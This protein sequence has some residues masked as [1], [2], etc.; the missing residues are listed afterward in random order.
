MPPCGEGC[1]YFRKS[2]RFLIGLE[3]PR[4]AGGKAGNRKPQQDIKQAFKKRLQ[5]SGLLI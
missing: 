1:V 5:K 4:A 3:N 2:L